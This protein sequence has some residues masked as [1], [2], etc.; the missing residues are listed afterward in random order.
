MLDP[1]IENQARFQACDVV[2]VPN[3]SYPIHAFGFLMA[4][5]VIRSVPSAPTPDYFAALERAMIR[6]EKPGSSS[7]PFSS[8][9]GTTVVEVVVDDVVVSA[10]VIG[11]QALVTAALTASI[12]AVPD[13]VSSRRRLSGSFVGS[14]TSSPLTPGHQASQG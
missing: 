9:T 11:A 2:L 13:Q 4:G 10:G 7:S 6:L 12:P 3:P 1:A 14:F 8:S 5:G